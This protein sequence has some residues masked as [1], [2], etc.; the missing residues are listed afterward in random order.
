MGMPVEQAHKSAG[1]AALAVA[2]AAALALACAL[3]A[4]ADEAGEGDGFDLNL[5]MEVADVIDPD[6]PVHPV[7]VTVAGEDGEPVAGA[8]V[9][10]AFLEPN[11]VYYVPPE[12]GGQP[13]RYAEAPE[14]M[15][16][17]GEAVT[18]GAG[19]A[20]VEGVVRGCDYEV[21]A[22]A[23][24]YAPYAGTHTCRGLGSEAWDVVMQKAPDESGSLGGSGGSDASLGGSAGPGGYGGFF[25]W[26][27]KT[28]DAMQPWL[29]ALAGVALSAFALAAIARRRKDGADA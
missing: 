29:L 26:L 27:A 5:S 6:A 13:G 21:R 19:K 25:R 7:T 4:A 11:S 3:P 2:A 10:Y 22:T 9:S 12:A 24:G 17:S 28:G 23:E 15:A 8:K 14:P 20:R 18:D 1:R 16:L